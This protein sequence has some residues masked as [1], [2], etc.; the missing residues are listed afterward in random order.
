M[1]LKRNVVI[2]IHYMSNGLTFEIRYIILRNFQGCLE[3]NRKFKDNRLRIDGEI[4]ENHAIPVNLT[5]GI[6]DL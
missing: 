2:S 4:A 5:A 3:L 6:I 1:G